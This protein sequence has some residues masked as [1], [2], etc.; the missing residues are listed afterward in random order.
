[1]AFSRRYGFMWES[2]MSDPL[3]ANTE[4]WIRKLSGSA[5]LGFYRYAANPPMRRG[6]SS[7][8]FRGR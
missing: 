1:M 2:R 4:V 7:L 3:P 5:G 6:R 8:S